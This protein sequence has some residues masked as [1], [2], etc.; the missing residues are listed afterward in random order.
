MDGKLGA[1]HDRL[2]R[3]APGVPLGPPPSLENSLSMRERKP[4]RVSKTLGGG[5]GRLGGDGG[6]WCGWRAI[7]R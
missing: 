3:L 5:D 6:E 4:S 2:S 1:P 7:D